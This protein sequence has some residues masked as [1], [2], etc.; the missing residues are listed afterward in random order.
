VKVNHQQARSLLAEVLKLCLEG[1][2]EEAQILVKQ[3]MRSTMKGQ[4][5]GKKEKTT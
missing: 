3:Q 2:S 4:S 5:H 1:K